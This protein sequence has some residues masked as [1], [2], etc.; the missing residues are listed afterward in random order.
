M[1][2]QELVLATLIVA[3][4][5]FIGCGGFVYHPQF[6]KAYFNAYENPHVDAIKYGQLGAASFSEFFQ[7]FKSMTIEF[8]SSNGNLTSTHVISFTSQMTIM[9]D[10]S[11]A[12]LINMTGTAYTGNLSDEDIVHIWLDP[13]TS[14]VI[15][16]TMGQEQWTGKE[17]QQEAGILGLLTTNEWLSLLNSTTVSPSGAT[18][19]VTMGSLEL[20]STTYVG[21]GTLPLYQNLVATVGTIPGSG[22][23][24]VLSSSYTAPGN[25][26]CEFQII[27]M[28]LNQ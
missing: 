23:Q 24:I 11:V 5:V 22:M 7:T 26:H 16:V 8:N 14:Y 28:G 4:I 12:Y 25:N 1:M 13:S 2:K 17:A 6:H 10:G 15:E 9:N 18:H 19:A 21:L 3:M 20:P 27:S